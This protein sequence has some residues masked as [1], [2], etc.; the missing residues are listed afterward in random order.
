MKKTSI[1]LCLLIATGNLFSQNRSIN[2]E[3]STWAEVVAKATKENKPIFVD[4]YTTWCGPCKWLSK[5]VFTNDTVADYFNANFICAKI[6]MEKGEGIELAKKWKVNAYPTL[7][8]FD[9]NGEPIHRT[10]GA[11][12]SPNGSKTFLS[13]GKDAIN[14]EKQFITKQKKYETGNNDPD[15]LA[16]YVFSLGKVC[17]P[18]EEALK[19]YFATQDE[20]SLTEKRNWKMIYYEVSDINSREFKYL[21]SHA[22]DFSKLYTKDSVTSKIE[23]TYNRALL[24]LAY[25]DDKTTEYEALKKEIKANA[26]INSEKIILGAELSYN[27]KKKNWTNYCKTADAYVEKYIF[28]DANMLNDV[29]WTFYENIDDKALLVKAARWAKRSVELQ[30]DYASMDTYAALLY[31]IGKKKEAKEAAEKAIEQGKKENQDYKSTEDLL[32]K[33]NEMK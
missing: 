8:Y 14:P 28:N 31:K 11:D 9:L 22:E 21:I 6:D 20:K 26:S 5:N 17:L 13:D 19:K 29:A 25:A 1:L 2:F 18:K 30:P 23:T 10:C 7:L 32:K 27:K 15:F 12:M 16:D 24:N 3:N 4:A 33:I